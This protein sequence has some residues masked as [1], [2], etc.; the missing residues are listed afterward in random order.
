VVVASILADKD[1]DEMLRLLAR[2]GRHLVAT[3]SDNARALPASELARLAEPYFERVDVIADSSAALL[4]AR[5]SARA[6]GVLVTGS[7]YLLA[8]L[9][10]VRSTHV[11][12]GTLATG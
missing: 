7:L 10:T 3:Q 6:A 11:P 4:S 1:V 9:R 12:W 8:S 5:E 2:V